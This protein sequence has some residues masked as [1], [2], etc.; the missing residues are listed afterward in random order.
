[1]PSFGES[2]GLAVDLFPQSAENLE[3]DAVF[4]PARGSFHPDEVIESGEPQRHPE[5]RDLDCGLPKL[6][7][8][9]AWIGIREQVDA[10]E[11]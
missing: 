6:G 1:L 3:L 4:G 2:L 11:S 10:T 8:V 9:Q 7:V 5:E